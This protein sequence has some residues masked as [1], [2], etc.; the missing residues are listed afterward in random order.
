MDVTDGSGTDA[1][2]AP[3]PILP[4]AS[5]WRNPPSRDRVLGQLSRGFSEKDIQ[6]YPTNELVEAMKEWMSKEDSE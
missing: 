6:D 5:H 3:T 2:M 4:R 1:P